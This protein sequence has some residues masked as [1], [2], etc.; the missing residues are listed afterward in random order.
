MNSVS[1][2][3]AGS[4]LQ[5]SLK[6]LANNFS[7]CILMA[8]GCLAS[9]IA[10]PGVA[11]ADWT[12]VSGTPTIQLLVDGSCTQA[13]DTGFQINGITASTDGPALIYMLDGSGIILDVGGF[14]VPVTDRNIGSILFTIID[15]VGAPFTIVFS[16]DVAVGFTPQQPRGSTYVNSTGEFPNSRITFDPSAVDPDCP[17][18]FNTDSQS[19][20]QAQSQQQ[21]GSDLMFRQ[22]A[23]NISS[24]TGDAVAERFFDGNGNSFEGG[25]EDGAGTSSAYTSLRG[26]RLAARERLKRR[27]DIANG[28]H[29]PA[30]AGSGNWV[31]QGAQTAIAA[32]FPD[33]P[34]AINSFDDSG[35]VADGVR[36]NASLLSYEALSDPPLDTQQSGWNVWVRGTFTNFDGDAFSGSTWHGIAGVD[37][38]YTANVLVGAIAGYEG[39]DFDFSS[40]N[41]AFE[42]EGFSAGAYVGVR[43]AD[44]LVMDAFLTHT[45][46]DYDN[47]VGT[48]TGETDATRILVSVNLTGRH[49]VTDNLII[50]PNAR[51]F[52]GHESQDDYTLSNGSVV[53]A[54]GI[55]AGRISVGSKFRYLLPD[56]SNGQWSVFASAHA[57]YDLSSEVQTSTTLPEFNDLFSARLGF[58]IDGTLLNGWIIQLAGDVGGLGS[59]SYTSYTGT[60]RVRIPLN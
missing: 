43:L 26:M 46:L 21:T 3:A 27:I 33:A 14:T 23:Q 49:Q 52:Y 50:E 30:R 32:A 36:E 7:S 45:W 34:Q 24:G 6:I 57:E 19:N 31:D 25:L 12:A 54:N 9:C 28:T 5:H 42:G 10:I 1:A 60:G 13:N 8:L 22:A 35:N 48:R 17:G 38:L 18:A 44:N 53:G 37:Y 41:G 20:A 40:T 51:V 55:D 15:P 29:E 16:N 4:G 56:R 59:G 2:S 11:R 39:G 58:G 47:R